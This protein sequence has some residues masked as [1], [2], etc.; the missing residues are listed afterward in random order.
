M[1][2]TVLDV[3]G[4][5]GK[6]HCHCR[7]EKWTK[8]SALVQSLLPDLSQAASLRFHSQP[9]CRAMFCVPHTALPSLPALPSHQ[10]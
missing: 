6:Q 1:K 8:H 9:P 4:K 2:E 7:A 3:L 5:W 10:P